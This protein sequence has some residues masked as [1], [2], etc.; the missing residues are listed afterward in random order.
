MGR[1]DLGLI[2][3][4]YSSFYWGKF[5]DSDGVARVRLSPLAWGARIIC[6]VLS[7][8]FL[9]TALVFVLV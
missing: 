5:S 7:L 3:A 9:L 1:G 2:A 6:Y 8:L 4:A